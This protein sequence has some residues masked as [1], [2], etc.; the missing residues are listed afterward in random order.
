MVRICP[1]QEDFKAS[2][3]DT[4]LPSI[5]I[6]SSV[7]RTGLIPKN[8]NVADP[9]FVGVEPGK[10]EISIPPVSVCHQVSTIGH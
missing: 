8:G 5:S 2:K 1:G 9:G 10:G 4:L 7:K 3:P 6:P